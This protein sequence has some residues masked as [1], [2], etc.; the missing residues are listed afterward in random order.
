MCIPCGSSGCGNLVQGHGKS[1]RG[2]D[3]ESVADKDLNCVLGRMCSPPCSARISPRRPVRASCPSAA[4]ARFRC[5]DV[6]FLFSG[7][8]GL[9]GFAPTP[10]P[11]I[12]SQDSHSREVIVTRFGRLRQADTRRSSTCRNPS[13][14]ASRMA[15]RTVVSETPARAATLPMGSVQAPCFW[16]SAA[17]T[18]RTAC[19]A[20]V[21]RLASAGGK[22]PAEAQRRRRS[23]EAGVSR[24]R[25]EPQPYGLLS[26]RKGLSKLDGFRQGRRLGLGHLARPHTPSTKAR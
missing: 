3:G 7:I 4:Q 15:L 5:A 26:G 17:T 12:R 20:S 10:R 25:A 11:R 2:G 23:R 1:T 9:H 24:P 21:N 13:R 16:C 22:A 14:R 8:R 6:P 18:A 19:S